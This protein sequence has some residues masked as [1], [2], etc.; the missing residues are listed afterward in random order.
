MENYMKTP[1]WND[2]LSEEERIEYLLRELF[3]EEKF[4]CLG[5]GNREFPRLGIPEFGVGGEAAHGVQARNDQGYDTGKPAL[6]TILPNPIGMSATWDEELIQKAGEMVGNEARGL[7]QSGKHRSLCLWAPTVDME[8]DPRWGRTEEGYGEDPCLTAKMAGAYVKG[9]QGEHPYFLRCGATLK[10]FYA[11]NA[12]EGR[13]YVSS[14]I[15]LRNKYEYYLE[16]FRRIAQEYH[17]LG[18]M[19]AYNE[20]NGIPAMLLEEEIALLKKWG[21]C[22][23]VCDG[24]DVS[25]TVNFHKYFSRHS[26]TIAGGLKAQI[27]CFTDDEE[28]ICQAAKEAVERGM[29]TEKQIDAALSNYFRVM[30]RLGFFDREKKNPYA[31]IGMEA[32]GTKENHA[33]ARK[34]TAESVILLKNEGIL[35]L[36]KQDFCKQGRKLAVLGPLSDVWF[37]DWY[38]GIPPYTVTPA[39]G[40]RNVIPEGVLE[41][42]G[43]SW[44]KFRMHTGGYLGIMEDG[45]SIGLVDET[46]AETFRMDFWGD[47]RITLRAGSNGLLL[48]TQDDT[49]KGQDGAVYAMKEEAF[50]WF[51]REIFYWKDGKLLAWDGQ[52]LTIDSEGRLRRTDFC[53]RTEKDVEKK[54]EPGDGSTT[55]EY[56][57]IKDGI[58]AAV[59]TAKQADTVLLFLGPNPMINC[60]EEIDRTHIALPPYQEELLQRICKVNKKVVFVLVSSIPFD[61]S[62]AKEHA[63]GILTCAS[64]SMELGNGLADV[65]F[66]AE[67]PA[68]CLNM[69]WYPSAADLP[70]MDDYDIIQGKR[71]YQYYEGRALYPFGHGLTYSVVTYDRMQVNVRENKRIQ[72]SLIVSNTGKYMTDQVVQIYV[73]KSG[74]EIQRPK[75]QLAGFRRIKGLAAG[76]QREVF[77]EITTD[78]FR[79]Y[80]VISEEMLLEPGK[81]EIMAGKSSEEILLRQMLLLEGTKR[82]CRDGFKENKAE[83]FDRA[84]NHVLQEGHLG[85][86]AVCTKNSTDILELSFDKMYFKTIP[87]EIIL[88]FWKEYPCF[89][90]VEAD[91]KQIGSCTLEGPLQGQE[92][93]LAAGQASGRGAFEAHRNWL[94]KHREIGYSEISVPVRDV[95][96]GTEFTLTIKWQGKGKL[97]TYRFR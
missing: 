84:Q 78:N 10:H 56:I 59:N 80:D 95:P 69:T 89:I 46:H 39:Q 67:G 25:Q 9:L 16:P 87:Q 57:C 50:G 15:D 28:L 94:T 96:V 43:V 75:K 1:L 6:T 37:K 79:Y 22:Y 27:D 20:V 62:Y 5:T 91:G 73:R 72:V 85:Y 61:I 97:C 4:R 81:Y 26:E 8:R 86:V 88:D 52:P 68:G 21:I 40:I 77:L 31:R 44:G 3:M 19:T 60:K 55:V 14:S 34:I 65:I 66:G 90:S 41:E 35:P 82:P 38:S 49:G 11:N 30:L 12:E 7:Y 70:P 48:T 29:I 92:K 83:C 74:S 24:G 64:G 93:Q 2:T 42:D 36:R 71:T 54:T 63:A 45:K 51:V 58:A 33:L 47:D 23:V 32:V 17:A 76:E 18:V 13:T 53:E